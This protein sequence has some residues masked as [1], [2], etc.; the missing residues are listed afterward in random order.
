MTRTLLG[1]V[2]A[3][4]LAGCGGAGD[5]ADRP[6][7]VSAA[8]SLTSAFTAYGQAFGGEVRF[9]FAGSDALAA[10]IRQGVKPD[11]YAAAS[12]ALP[13]ALHAEGLVEEP[14]AFAASRLVIAVAAGDETIRSIADLAQP[15]TTIALGSEHVPIGAYARELLGRL[16]PER[17]A[18]ILA[19]VRSNEP[20]AK[21]I[22][23][24][25]AQGAATSV[26]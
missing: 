10:Q 11:V 3:A 24:K 18:A 20:D 4:A 13:A 8:S 9:S 5:G 14:V 25:L 6:L 19:N 26:A 17:A 23:G 22:V 21:G 16:G 7:V 15:G 12:P 1:L 2:L